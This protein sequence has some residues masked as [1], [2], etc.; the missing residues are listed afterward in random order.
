MRWGTQERGEA[1]A[2]GTCALQQESL[3]TLSNESVI[4]VCLDCGMCPVRHNDKLDCYA[5]DVCGVNSTE[6]IVPIS[7]SHNFQRIHHELSSLGLAP[8]VNVN[9]VGNVAS[10]PD[11][12]TFVEGI[13]M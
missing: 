9:I 5:C 8:R 13:C 3:K 7:S 10:E 2:L 6:R 11:V 12:K 4:H 1:I